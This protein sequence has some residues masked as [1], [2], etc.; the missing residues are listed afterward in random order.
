MKIWTT[1]LVAWVVWLPMWAAAGQNTATRLTYEVASIRASD[2]DRE[3]GS[4]QPLL[5]GVGYTVDG[6]PLRSMLS[7]M[8]RI[9][10]RQISGGP[11]WVNT[12]NYDVYGRTDHAYSIDDLHLMFENLLADRFN[13]KLHTEQVPGPVYVLRAARSGMKMKPVDVGTNRRSPIWSTTD[14]VTADGVPLNYLCYWLGQVLQGDERPVVDG[15]GLTGTYDFN[16]SFRWPE[17]P[18]AGGDDGRSED[19]P[20][21]FQALHDQLG[22]DLVPEKGMVTK[23]IIDHAEKPSA[24]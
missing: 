3:S 20:T 8:Y 17:E 19:L 16:L 11:N 5:N 10:R 13:L 2:P 1:A 15:T 9:P 24:N 6:L 18:K 22:L 12:E 14:G 23:L 21:I 4:V 7:V